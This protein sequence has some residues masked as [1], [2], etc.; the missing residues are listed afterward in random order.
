MR[1]L[2]AEDDA[3]SR[4]IL[5]ASLRRWGHDVIAVDNGDDAWRILTGDDP[6]R[7]AVIDWMMPG[8]DGPEVCEQLRKRENQPFTFVLILTAKDNTN[9]IVSALNS[10][11]DDY[12]TKPYHPQELRSRLGAGIRLVNLTLELEDANRK[13]FEA[14]HTD[15]LTHIPNRS[16]ILARL[17]DQISRSK[18]SNTP[19]VVALGDI[20]HFKLFNDEHGH[21]TGDDVLIQVAER[22]EDVKREYDAVGRYGGEEFLLVLDDVDEDSILPVADRFRLSICEKPIESDGQLLRV[23]MSIG[24]LWVPPENA[25]G[26]DILLHEADELLYRAKAEGRNRCCVDS[27]LI[28]PDVPRVQNG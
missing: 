17:T 20:D 11:A 1:V 21:K 27:C 5:E 8:L 19:F 9:D 10:G 13:L 2:V 24:A 6:P 26:V 23:A 3:V 7:I 22:L 4:K 15:F 16:A 18:R 28:V 25:L 12:L 14:A